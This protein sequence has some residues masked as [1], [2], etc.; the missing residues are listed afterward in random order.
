MAAPREREA[1]EAAEAA[2]AAGDEHVVLVHATHVVPAVSC[3]K[4]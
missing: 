3:H 4:T 2:V 1:D